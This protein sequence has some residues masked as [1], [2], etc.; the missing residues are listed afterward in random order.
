MCRRHIAFL[1]STHHIMKKHLLF[2]AMLA[3]A[4]SASA[5]GIVNL[6]G[7]AFNVDTLRHVKVGPGTMHT[8]MLLQSQTSTKKMRVHALTM[9]LRGHDNVEYRMEIGNDTTLTTERISSIAKRKSNENTHYFA[10]VNADFYITTS[11]VPQY[12]GQPHMDCILNGE[13]AST[14]Y[15]DAADYGHFFM[16]KDK[17]MWCDS[18]T[19]SFS[20]SFPDGSTVTMPRINQDI[21]ENEMVMFNSKF[22]RQ[23]RFA[24]CTEVQVALAEGETWAVNRP[25]KLVVTSAPNTVGATPITADGAVLSATGT[26][27]AKIAALKAGDNLTANF[28]ITLKDYAI[29]PDIKECSGGDVVILKRGQVT[30]EAPRF[31]NGRDSNNPRTMF[32]YDQ[33]R[34]KMVWCIIDGR[35][36]SSDGSTYPEGADIMTYLGCYDAVNVDGG[37]SSGM[38]IEP[39]GIVNSPSDGSERAV[40][41][42]LFAVLK[43]PEDNTITE[44]RFEDWTMVLP[45]Y[46]FY[47]PRLYGYNQYGVLIDTDLQ[48]F[49]LS[50]PATLGEITDNGSALF[51]NGAGTHNLTATYNGITTSIVVTVDNSGTPEMK[52]DNVLLDNYRQWPAAIQSLVNGQYMAL[53]PEALTWSSAD[54]S[55]ATVNAA[56]GIVQGV[57]NGTTTL[58]GTVGDYSGTINVTVQCPEGQEMPVN[59]AEGISSWKLTK[60]NLSS[61]TISEFGKG[62]AFDYAIKTTRGPQF[63]IAHD[64][65]PIWSLPDSLRIRI[66]PVGEAAITSVTANLRANNSTPTNIPFNE[67]T[68]GVE[69]VL[70]IPMSNLGDPNDIG[71]YPVYINSITVVVKG[72]ASTDYRIEIPAIEA[73][74]NNAPSG[75]ETI[76]ISP[77]IIPVFVANGI[78]TTRR[79]VDTIEIYNLLGQKVAAA[80]HTDSIAAPASGSYII[81]VTADGNSSSHKVL[82]Q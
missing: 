60:S 26:Q 43:S 40:S 8:S 65:L 1:T 59:P 53:S 44:I 5:A 55:I 23:T 46:G 10:G 2:T 6:Q 56:T 80:T 34:T 52:Y 36:N 67:V 27:A 21:Y 12:A 49:T 41:N 50:C 39:F 69:N 57:K 16:D 24:G 17:N 70:S 71:I 25:V 11:Y 74:Y 20:I 77:D 4:T 3:L 9:D 51:G 78:I 58:T 18:P 13:I 72:K 66:K 31:I 75:I 42:G 19:Q 14:G 29:S 45:K 37:G 62:V 32:G 47:I 22:G 68:S 30:F 64:S 79:I 61:C 35:S 63:K 81:K 28:A 76:V 33:D 73:V 15:L 54:E 48:G 7:T 82:I 38:Y